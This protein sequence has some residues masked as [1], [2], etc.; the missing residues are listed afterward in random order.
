MTSPPWDNKTTPEGEAGSPDRRFVIPK[1]FI[2][3]NLA[4][5]LLNR[6]LNPKLASAQP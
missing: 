2:V 5:D 3:S 6:Q 1:P 4:A